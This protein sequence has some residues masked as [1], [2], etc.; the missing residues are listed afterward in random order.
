MYINT[1]IVDD[2]LNGTRDNVVKCFWIFEKPREYTEP[3][4][5][6]SVKSAIKQYYEEVYNN[7]VNFEPLNK[8]VISEIFPKWQQVEFYVDLIVGFPAPYDA[9]TKKD[10]LGRVHIIIDLYR[11]SEYG[12]TS[13]KLERVVRNLITHEMTHVL[14]EN[15]FPEIDLEDVGYIEKL[16]RI[17]FNEG[18]AHFLSFNGEGLEDINWNDTEYEEVYL[19]SKEKLKEALSEKKPEKQEK[20][21]EEADTGSYFEKYGAMSGLFYFAKNWKQGGTL[22][23]KQMVEH[24]YKDM[25]NRILMS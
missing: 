22:Q 14:V 12:L 24:G 6:D 21:L 9:V 10:P 16:N 25:V 23:L 5:K 15:L 19:R 1:S 3:E 20:Y 18:I 8:S 4:N 2:Y 17:T 7:L 11:L 13:E